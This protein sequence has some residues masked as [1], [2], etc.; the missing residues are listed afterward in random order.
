MPRKKPK[1]RPDL[2]EVAFRVLQEATGER[3]KTDPTN[4][5]KNPEAVKRG[6]R[7][8]RPNKKAD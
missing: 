3:P 1:L 7:G 6:R 8:G 4:R 5:E 2:N